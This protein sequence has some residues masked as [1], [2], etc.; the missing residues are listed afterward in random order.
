MTTQPLRYR[1][2]HIRGAATSIFALS[3]ATALIT[4]GKEPQRRTLAW[5]F[6]CPEDSVRIELVSTTNGLDTVQ[7]TIVRIPL[8]DPVSNVPEYH[9][10]QRF[11]DSSQYGSTYAI[12]AAFR[13]DTVS[14]G[15]AVP[16]ATIYTPDGTY[17]ALGI[18]PG[19]NCLVLS[20]ASSSWK[21]MM[22]P[23]GQGEA[24]ADCAAGSSTTGQ[25]LDVLPQHLP[26]ELGFGPSDFPAAARWD[27]DSVHATQYIGIRCGSEWCEVGAKGFRPSR[28]YEGSDLS[29]EGVPNAAMT[30]KIRQRVQRIKGW[31][32]TQQLASGSGA[33]QAPSSVNGVL[34]PSPLLDQV[35]WRT[36]PLEVYRNRWVHVGYAVLDG[37]YGKWHF[38]KGANKI[39]LCYGT[40]A[41]SSCKVPP[42]ATQENA[43]SV[44][45]TACSADP[46]S[47]ALHWYARTVTAVGD[48]SYGC[49]KR[50][51][52]LAQLTAFSSTLA[53]GVQYSIP[54][55]A[56]WKFLLDD[57][58]TWFS[59]PTGCCTK[60]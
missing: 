8:S 56:R 36:H 35:N 19:F 23:R 25:P 9:D 22:V 13:L 15:T 18:K 27:W 54:G 26:P 39:F 17:G 28:P 11:I 10:C 46:T 38:K 5:R 7:D 6:Q 3:I 43:K 24:A 51:D 14:G 21:A 4:C 45:L 53:P 34:I 1:A 31:Y 16:V 41:A 37:D 58:S 57:E 44:S 55:T 47:P 52:H 20:K 12:F 33:T 30:A 42:S 29:F 32:D 48:T 59:C 60:Q 50:M 2:V 40:A 49:V